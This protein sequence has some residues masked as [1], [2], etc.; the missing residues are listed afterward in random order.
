M[1]DCRVD[2]DVGVLGGVVVRALEVVG[3]VVE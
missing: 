3:T 2:T 1:M